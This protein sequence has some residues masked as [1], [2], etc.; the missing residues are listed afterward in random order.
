LA[1]GLIVRTAPLALPLSLSPGASAAEFGVLRFDDDF[2]AHRAT[3]SDDQSIK[4]CGL[5]SLRYRKK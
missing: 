5:A 1:A 2:I 4:G 3:C